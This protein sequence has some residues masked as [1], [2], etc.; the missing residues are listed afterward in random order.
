MQENMVS[1]TSEIMSWFWVVTKNQKFQNLVVRELGIDPLKVLKCSHD[2]LDQFC[3]LPELLKFFCKKIFRCKKQSLWR[4]VTSQMILMPSI[5][6]TKMFT[7]C[8]FFSL[9]ILV[10]LVCSWD[11]GGVCLTLFELIFFRKLFLR[12]LENFEKV[13]MILVATTHTERARYVNP[14][15]TFLTKMVTC[16]LFCWCPFE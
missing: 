11:D 5:L 10:L 2:Q 1:W 7:F 14:F 4:I 16:W 9:K 3:V 13:W 8:W 6:L 15:Y 12:R